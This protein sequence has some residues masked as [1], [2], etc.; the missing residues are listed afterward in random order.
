MTPNFKTVWDWHGVT[1]IDQWD[2]INCP[3]IDLCTGNQFISSN[4]NQDDHFAK[5]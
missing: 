5:W 4:G 1:Y 3:E 2:R